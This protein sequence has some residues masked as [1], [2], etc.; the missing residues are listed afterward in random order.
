LIDEG[1]EEVVNKGDGYFLWA[2]ETDAIMVFKLTSIGRIIT[3][4]F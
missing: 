4:V 2:E 3:V 1:I